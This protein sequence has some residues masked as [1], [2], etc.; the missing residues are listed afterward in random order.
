MNQSKITVRYA[1][2]FF[3]LA[4][5]SG[6]IETLHR[7]IE[8]VYRLCHQSEDFYQL[9]QNPVI[10]TAQ[11]KSILQEILKPHIHDVTLRFLLLI[12]GKNRETEIP[13]ICRNIIDRV[14]EERGIVPATVTTAQEMKPAILEEIRLNLER[15]TGKI[16]E[17]THKM[18][19]AILGGMI[20]RVGDLQFDGSISTQLKKVKSTLLAK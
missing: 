19:P 7:D 20:L 14:R 8:M 4:K 5:D 12:T 3:S 18:N 11:K 13:G 17:L 15:E 2:A 10:K 6:E 1:K 9:L 16:V